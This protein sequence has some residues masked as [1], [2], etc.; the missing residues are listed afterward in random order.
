MSGKLDDVCCLV[1]PFKCRPRYH[2]SCCIR[3]LASTFLTTVVRFGVMMTSSKGNI[4]ALLTIYAGNSPVP[5]EFPAQRP[6]TRSFGVFFDMRLNKRLSKQ[7]RGWWF[8]T[9][10]RSLSRQCNGNL[11]DDWWF[12]IPPFW[13]NDVIEYGS[14]NL[15]PFPVL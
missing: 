14:G 3:W 4:S 6:V 11:L 10:S 5:G 12:Q 2:R 7:S 8:E 1:A 9:P 13:P 15:A